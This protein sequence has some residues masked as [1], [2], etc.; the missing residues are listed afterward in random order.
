MKKALTAEQMAKLSTTLTKVDIPELDGVAYIKMPGTGDGLR[1]AKIKDLGKRI[2]ATAKLLVK[3]AVD[4]NG[5]RIFDSVRQINGLPAPIGV[6][7]SNA[8]AGLKNVSGSWPNQPQTIWNIEL[9]NTT[10]K[11]LKR[12]NLPI[13]P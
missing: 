2:D 3:L 13:S 10:C 8:L 11:A 6:R 4:E 1:L 7:L 12:L 9:S 5:K